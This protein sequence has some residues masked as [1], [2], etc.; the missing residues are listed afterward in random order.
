MREGLRSGAAFVGAV[1]VVFGS[2]YVL[3]RYGGWSPSVPVKPETVAKPIPLAPK[4]DYPKENR[5]EKPQPLPMPNEHA[6]EKRQ[7]R[8]FRCEVNGKIVY[9]DAPC[10]GYRSTEVSVRDSS[11]VTIVDP[12]KV[13]EFRIQALAPASGRRVSRPVADS[14]KTQAVANRAECDLVDREIKMLDRLARQPLS[15]REQDRIKD[16]R[17]I[18]VQRRHDLNCMYL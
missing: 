16:E 14:P 18:L 1:V 2:L 10:K 9:T 5:T 4:P 15:G 8:I 13:E 6:L 11:G 7:G 12:R 17:R 3:D